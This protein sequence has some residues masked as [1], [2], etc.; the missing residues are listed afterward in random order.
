MGSQVLL[1]SAART[2]SGTSDDIAVGPYASATF[3]LEVTAA[4][5][6]VDDTL[7]VYVQQLVRPDDVTPIY[8]DFVHFTQV[9]GNGGAK[10]FIGEQSS[11]ASPESELHAPADAALAAGILQ[12]P[13]FGIWR[14]KWVIVDAG[15]DNASFTFGL[16]VYTREH[17]T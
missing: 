11:M 13:K 8:D 5:T 17:L 14:V 7:D 2:A 10:R 3:L 9:L 1:A 16:W 6:A 12:G 15:A 4:A